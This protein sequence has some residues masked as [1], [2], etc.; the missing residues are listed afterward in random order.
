MK[1]IGKIT[2]Q[3]LAEIQRRGIQPEAA[4]EAFLAEAKARHPDATS[5]IKKST[6]HDGF[7]IV[8]I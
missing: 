7:D 3:Q 4:V 5:I 1:I 2:R 8:A 6:A